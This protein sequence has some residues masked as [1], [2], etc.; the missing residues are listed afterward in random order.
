MGKSNLKRAG[1]IVENRWGKEFSPMNHFEI[2]KN[3]QEYQK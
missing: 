1:K 3:K 2:N